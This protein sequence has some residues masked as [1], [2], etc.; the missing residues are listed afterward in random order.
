MPDFIPQDEL[1]RERNH[2]AADRSLLSFVRSSLTLISIGVA[3]DQ[4]V[5]AIAPG[6]RFIDI[7]AYGLSLLLVGLGVVTLALA[8]RDYQGEMQRLK[9]PVYLYT[10]RWPLGSTT[11]LLVL[12]VGILAF[13]WLGFQ[14]WL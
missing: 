9:A 2:L 10:P 6:G 4:V 3:V 14:L 7:W 1:A 12:L 5:S 11:G 8:I 13:L